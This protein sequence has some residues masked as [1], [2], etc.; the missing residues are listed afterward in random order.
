MTERIDQKL[1]EEF[2][3]DHNFERILTSLN[4]TLAKEEKSL[5][6]N[7]PE[8]YPT[9][10]IIGAPRSGTTLATQILVSF[11]KVGYINNLIAAFWKAPTYGI[12]LS[13]RLLGMS[14]ISNFKS[15]FGR[16]D[17]I[18]EP[19]EFGYFWNYHLNYKSLEQMPSEHEDSINWENLGRLLNNMS[20]QFGAPLVFKSFLFGFHAKRAFQELLKTCFIY[21]KRDFISNAFSILKL[22]KTLNGSIEEWGSIKP[23]QY[24]QLKN[25][26]V[27]EQIAG[28]IMCLEH[29]YLKQ[30]EKLPKENWLVYHYE[31]ICKEP[32]SFLKK[33]HSLIECH[34][35]SNENL[36]ELKFEIDSYPLKKGSYS[37]NEIKQFLSAQQK[38]RKLFPYLKEW[39][40]N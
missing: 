7:C 26:S 24:E 34:N 3:K 30:I 23:I 38:I 25:L 11:L 39:K 40:E 17:S 33:T 8:K 37:P 18:R 16:T 29:E 5:L 27:Y 13:K 4:N 6:L 19:H 31:D 2:S 10:H 28:Q 21:I 15:N 1:T 35:S 20:N 14:Y 12:E 32:L 9:L 22:R 36:K